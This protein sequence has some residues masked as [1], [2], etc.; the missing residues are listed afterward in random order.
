MMDLSLFA[1]FVGSLAICMVLI[2]PL[3][4]SAA[5]FG[6]IDLPG[7]RRVHTEPVARVGGIG[8]AAG[9]LVS[10]W[11]WAPKDGPVLTYLAGAGLLLVSGLWD[12]SRGLGFRSKFAVQCAAALV[13]VSGGLWIERVP[14]FG[15]VPDWA[16]QALTVFALVGATN[17]VNLS[18]GLDGLAGGLCLLTFGALGYLAS[19]AA[20]SVIPVVAVSVLGATFAFLRFNTH[21]ARVFMGDSG[22]QFLGFS[23]GVL[24]VLLARV[25]GVET[26]PAVV[27]LALG[28]PIL[29]TVA[30]MTQR[31]AQGRSPFRPDRGH[32]HH[33]LL[34]MGFTH[35]EAVLAI[36]A[37]HAGMVALAISL[38]R[39]S[40]AMVAAVYGAAALPL[41]AAYTVPADRVRRV[42]HPDWAAGL[43]RVATAAWPGRAS[44]AALRVAVP[45]FLG[46]GVLFPDHV[47]TD[48]GVVATGLG[49]AIL[50][51]WWSRPA[52]ALWVVRAGWYVGGAFIVYLSDRHLATAAGSDRWP[53][54]P[55]VLD[56]WLVLVAALV[57]AALCGRDRGEFETTPLDYLIAFAAVASLALPD[58]WLGD[59][60]FGALAVKLVVWFFGVE[61]V[62][63][64]PGVR[65]ARLGAVATW[66]LFGL[67]FRAWWA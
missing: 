23:A 67:G 48:F 66:V 20:D 45:A 18:D 31:L 11:L 46:A 32:L 27:L 50:I 59:A 36:Y 34:E 43:R 12:D 35:R 39:A 30:V 13:V 5:R 19:L 15:A 60:R 47:P 22:S 52:A 7:E 24:A 21:P 16:G 28:I 9:A 44:L 56:G 62:L 61:I 58:L 25:Q 6:V 41:V 53:T 63:S 14:F 17:A 8:L 49:V 54:V 57:L 1:S 2:P 40:D 37:A 51:G 26:S 3:R 55:L 10:V 33:K 65:L 38:A 29:D 4:A 64:A 42:V